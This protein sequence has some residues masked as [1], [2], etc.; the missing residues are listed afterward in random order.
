MYGMLPFT[1]FSVVTYALV[2]AALLIG[3]AIAKWRQN[4]A[5]D[6]NDSAWD[7]VFGSDQ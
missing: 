5:T 7:D 6:D 4:R 3:G 2:G 1:G